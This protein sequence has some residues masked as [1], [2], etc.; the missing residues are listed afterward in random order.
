MSSNK[1]KRKVSVLPSQTVDIN[2]IEMT[3][4]KTFHS[5]LMP[6]NA[7]LGVLSSKLLDLDLITFPQ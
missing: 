5:S 1:N 2:H 3:L 6:G 7:F 4:P